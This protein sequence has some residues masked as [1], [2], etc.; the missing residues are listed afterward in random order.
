M[1]MTISAMAGEGE[2]H[3]PTEIILNAFSQAAK[4]F[5]DWAASLPDGVVGVAQEAPS[6]TQ[7]AGARHSR[8]DKTKLEQ[9]LSLLTDI[10]GEDALPTTTENSAMNI[11]E[12]KNLAE[13]DPVGFLNIIRTAVK[14]A[15]EAGVTDTRKFMWGETG[16]EP[17]TVQEVM[18][19]LRDMMNGE[20]LAG[21]IADAV[22]GVDVN[23]AAMGDS[24]QVA[25]T[26]RSAFSKVVV[27]E[28]KSNP[29]GALAA[30]IKDAVAGSVAEAIKQVME[31]VFQSGQM[32]TVPAQTQNGHGLM[33]GFGHDD[34][35]VDED[36]GIDA[37][38]LIGETPTLN[39]P[40][41]RR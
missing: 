14:S 30:S 12:L 5:E 26:M 17:H 27:A 15:K 16:V 7:N 33:D 19:P 36:G 21:L 10:L 1:D 29:E 25:A 13:S 38:I 37:S 41:G 3:S 11:Q 6:E 20:M 2:G 39:S 31:Q 23:G 4:L 35:I 8:A 9:A 18:G 24:P 32:P 22:G 40:V 28:L 34:E